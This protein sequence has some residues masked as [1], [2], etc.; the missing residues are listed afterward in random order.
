MVDWKQIKEFYR[1]RLFNDVLPFWVNNAIDNTFGGF[2]DFLDQEGK[3]LST[4]KSGWVHG[5]ATWMFSFLY[6]TVDRNATWLAYAEHCARFLRDHMR[7]KEGRVYFEVNQRGEPLV[8]RRYLFS[9]VFAVIGFAELYKAS[10]NKEWLELA[11]QTLQVI[12]TYQGHLPEKIFSETRAMKGHSWT[13]ILISMYQILREA[14]DTKRFP[15]DA[16]IAA[17]IDEIFNV[18]VKEDRKVLLEMVNTDGSETEGCEGRCVNP[19]HAIETAWFVLREAALR[20]DDGLRDKA[21]QIID[22]HMEKGWDSVY[23][24]LFSFID[25]VNKQPAQVDWD[26]KYWWPHT[27]AL[28]ALLMAYQQSGMKKYINWF[29]KVHEYSW[30]HFPDTVHGEWFGYL[31]RDGS[32]ASTLKGNHYKGPFHLPRCLMM[33][34][35][36]ASELEESDK[37]ESN[38]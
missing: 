7:S 3:P 6:N 4:D 30:Q 37:L 24:G 32:V 26:M 31:H 13:M 27:E 14:D 1:G 20:K 35:Q 8:L 9:E 5:R 12:E 15:Y 33:V 25:S 2:L 28:I 21:L 22:W 23:G 11:F 29:E 16:L 19:G 36:I 18:F 38:E 34:S 17:Q 10:K